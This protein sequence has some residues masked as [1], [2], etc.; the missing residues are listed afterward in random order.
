[1]SQIS[2]IASLNKNDSYANVELFS[3][4]PHVTV[5][6]VKDGSDLFVNLF[7]SGA[8]TTILTP[9]ELAQLR[10]CGGVL[11]HFQKHTAYA[12][13]ANGQPLDISGVY[14]VTFV[15]LDTKITAP[16]LVSPDLERGIIGCNIILK[17]NL[18]PK[19]GD[20]EYSDEISSITAQGQKQVY[21]MVTKA[22]HMDPRVY[23]RGVPCK[24][25][26]EDG[27][28][29]VGKRSGILDTGEIMVRVSTD[30]NGHFR[31]QWPN[32]ATV[33]FYLPRGSRL[34]FMRPNDDYLPMPIENSQAAVGLMAKINAG[35]ESRRKRTLP[36]N[37]KK[38]QAE[39]D[40]LEIVKEGLE[41]SVSDPSRRR[42]YIDL[43]SEFSHVFSQSPTDLGFTDAVTHHVELRD[44]EPVYT[45]QYRLPPNEIQLIKD[46]IMAWLDLGIIEP[47][48]S[49]YNS[50]ILCVPKKGGN[51]LRVV[52][53]YRRLNDKSLPDKY[54]I[55]TIETCLEEIGHQRSKVFSCLDLSSGFWQMK[56]DEDSRHL[57]AFT[58]PGMGQFQW[59][60][61]PMGLMG[62]PA[63]FSRL[64][65]L[66][67]QDVTNVITYI[68]DVLAHTKN[69]DEHLVTLRKVL[70]K[71][72]DAN[73]KLNASKCIFGASEVP[74]LGH[75]ISESGFRPGQDKVQALR[76][77]PA[78][79]T[80]KQVR[81]FTGLANYF[82]QFIPRFAHV[83]APLYKLCRKDAQWTEGELPPDAMTAFKAIKNFICTEP[84][85]AYPNDEGDF[86]LYVDAALGDEHNEG[87]LGA[88]LMQENHCGQRLP[89]GFA[90][91]RLTD[92][93]KNYPPFVAELAAACYGMD[94][95]DTLL[96]HRRFYLY[97]DHKPMVGVSTRQ[98]KT[99][100]RL[101][102]KMQEM[103][104]VI[105]HIPGSENSVAD[106]LSR[107]A[108]MDRPS[109]TSDSSRRGLNPAKLAVATHRG[110]GAAASIDASPARMQ[111]LQDNDPL[112]SQIKERVTAMSNDRELFAVKLP[113]FPKPLF[114]FWNTLFAATQSDLRGQVDLKGQQTPTSI[115]KILVPQALV[116]EVVAEAHNSKF[117]GHNGAY[118]STQFIRQHFWWPAMEKDVAD[119]V[120]SCKT[121]QAAK[122]TGSPEGDSSNH[123]PI[124]SWPNQRIHA[125]LFGPLK[126]SNS[127]NSYICVITDA[128]TKYTHIQAIPDKSAQ[129]VSDAI[130]KWIYLFGVPKNIITDQGTEFCNALSTAIYKSLDVKHGTT[131][132][133][134]P[135]CNG[136]VESFNKTMAAY[137]RK[138]IA[139]AEASTMD[140]EIF[141]G[142]LMISYNSSTNSTTKI[143]SH[144]ALL[145][146]DSRL[147][148]WS[149]LDQFNKEDHPVPNNQADALANLRR[150]QITAQ[151]IAHHNA[152]HRQNI[153]D[154]DF[155][156][157]LDV[158]NY[159]AGDRVWV[160]IPDSEKGPNPKLSLKWEEGE[161]VG[162]K[163]GQMA[164]Y[165]VRRIHHKRKKVITINVQ[166][167]KPYV[168]GDADVSDPP[169]ADQADSN[170]PPALITEEEEAAANNQVQDEA[171]TE[172]EQDEHQEPEAEVDPFRRITRSMAR[173]SALSMD[174]SAKRV[175]DIM[176]M[177]NSGLVPDLTNEDLILLIN[178]GYV[179]A[180]SMPGSTKGPSATPA[181]AEPTILQPEEVL[182]GKM[183]NPKWYKK[184][185]KSM[186]GIFKGKSLRIKR[187][188]K[189]QK[190]KAGN[191]QQETFPSNNSVIIP[192]PMDVDNNSISIPSPMEADSPRPSAQSSLY[193][194][195]MP[196]LRDAMDDRYNITQHVP[197]CNH[198]GRG[199]Q[200]PAPNHRMTS[201]PQA[202]SHGRM[203]Y[204]NESPILHG[205]WDD[206]GAWQ[207]FDDHHPPPTPA[208]PPP[209]E[210]PKSRHTL[211]L[212]RLSNYLKSGPKDNTAPDTHSHPSGGRPRRTCRQ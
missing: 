202:E 138:A 149:G 59:T 164:V 47:S 116:P 163:D 120:K 111:V 45:A 28:D 93:E 153:A 26:N 135:Q 75:T 130:L 23:T 78:P 103:H 15:V 73:L 117:G 79:Q 169:Q 185:S 58:V 100:N 83:A 105:R 137:L 198:A 211:A 208:S 196:R 177:A 205:R 110:F 182:A 55:R 11:K 44:K 27:S 32:M 197:H 207:Q 210:K 157:R 36:Q 108:G 194:Q 54:S 57:T 174:Q 19:L 190:Q 13:T 152:Q 201:T 126:N 37:T 39:K 106:F 20:C 212:A 41:K 123:L 141:L 193:D 144:K 66:I 22:T 129:T 158:Y 52:L 81:S 84:L 188:A 146:F 80:A 154:Q 95:F 17:Y 161:I 6:Q 125:D 115:A 16:V 143:A 192:S 118:K 91:R 12:T 181:T 112:L 142:P 148:L 179:I 165:K 147:P 88:C 145:G 67:M 70:Q 77:I 24:L 173:V 10:A 127:G 96:K 151:K 189:P 114:I 61:C 51:Q 166:R 172:A 71:I 150:A 65:D 29:V 87:G 62:A 48:K 1:M 180:I 113:D 30:D 124:P 199:A 49:K 82:R 209:Q 191:H 175:T 2:Q 89:V 86:H 46:S 74:Y 155:D 204:H 162:R 72:S 167:L 76:D 53:D 206:M 63:S 168:Q 99:L 132:P 131:T 195:L 187:K 42:E 119:H 184:I 134:H 122:H 3:P 4:R 7:D 128:L 21:A 171:E 98:V 101:Q 159:E 107:Y 200:P 38:S 102:L 31:Y 160:R 64:M 136:Q 176:K 50:A 186:I 133:Y 92:S 9:D 183:K 121:C 5:R 104:P 139:D 56:L 97:T 8:A 156:N 94:Y 69:H 203:P 43:L 35:R 85:L 40:I 170:T 34:G 60:R 33:P 68:D 14:L 178:H 18:L 109:R 140:W 25:V 90:S